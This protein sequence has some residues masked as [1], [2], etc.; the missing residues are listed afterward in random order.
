MNIIVLTGNSVK[1]IDLKYNDNTGKAIGNGTIAVQRNYKNREGK[2]DT[3]FFNFVVMGKQAEVMAE[4]IKKGD[5]F[6]INGTLQNRVWEKENGDKQ[7]FTEVFVNGFD[8]PVKPKSSNQSN[9][10][11]PFKD[12]GTPV[13]ISDSD[14]PF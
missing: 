9:S 4:Y 11:D 1:D 7:Y 8:F 14:L 2:Y 13:D 5:K 6:G 3:D 12:N 10:Q